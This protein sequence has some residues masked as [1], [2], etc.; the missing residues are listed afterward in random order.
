MQFVTSASHAAHIRSATSPR[1][2]SRRIRALGARIACVA[3]LPAFAI[4]QQALTLESRNAIGNSTQSRCHARALSPD[5]RYAVMLG[6]STDMNPVPGPW[7]DIPALW[8]RDRTTGLNELVSV[9]ITGGYSSNLV[10][11]LTS[12]ISASISAD[13]RY[14]AFDSGASDLVAGDTNNRPDVFVRDRLAGV[15]T[16]VSVAHD[17]SEL[18]ERSSKPRLSGDGRYVLFATDATNVLP[19]PPQGS[20]GSDNTYR[21]EL[22][23]GA[24]DL[25]APY[26]AGAAIST[27]GRFVA[28]SQPLSLVPEDTNGAS[29]IYLRDFQS[30]S[31]T[32]VS[33]NASG[34]AANGAS[35]NPELSGDGSVVAFYSGAIDLVPGDSNNRADIFVRNLV[36]GTITI[37]SRH[38]NGAQPEQSASGLSEFRLSLDG[39]HVL[40]DTDS[41]RLIDADLNT[42]SDVFVHDVV[43]GE[44]Q[45]L[46]VDPNGWQVSGT[47]DYHAYSGGISADGQLVLF[48]SSA[49]LT[50][51]DP[52][53]ARSVYVHDRTIPVPRGF[54]FGTMSTCPCGNAGALGR[55]CQSGNVTVGVRLQSTGAVSVANDTL[56]LQAVVVPTGVS[57][58]FFQGTARVNGSIGAAFGDG[59]RCAGGTTTRLGI[60]TGAGGLAAYG[61][62]SGDVPVSTR[63]GVPAA[64]GTF[65]YQAWFRDATSFCTPAQYNLSNGLTITWIP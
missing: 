46:S 58:L 10:P 19:G 23:T 40:F 52:S 57:V 17:G 15:T 3:L 63:G 45:I 47:L 22:S 31:T 53:S 30:G 29:D 56:L 55:G 8:I 36:T 20:G 54:C 7:V 60:R 65:H 38:T 32:L 14:V 2:N 6:Y 13:G 1:S 50:A 43:S 18:P 21:Y 12:A 11:T 59:L 33:V 26:S 42:A 9:S 37:A 27:D 34:L 51:D 64:G 44:T 39:G 35:A 61:A 48:E 49:T 16:R 5:G 25:I 28:F 41:R 24:I 62:P 4:G